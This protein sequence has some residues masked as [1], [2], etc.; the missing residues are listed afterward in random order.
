VTLEEVDRSWDLDDVLDANELL[1]AY[2]EARTEG[3]R[4]AE[5]RAKER[6]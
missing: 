3:Q 5:E 6:R 2:E 1:D 4:K